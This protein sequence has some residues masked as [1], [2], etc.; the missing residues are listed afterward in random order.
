MFG[1]HLLLTLVCRFGL[2]FCFSQEV[3]PE[4]MDEKDTN[5]APVAARVAA[6]KKDE[7]AIEDNRR[8]MKIDQTIKLMV[9]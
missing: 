6:D 3:Q 1:L 4:L 5:V 7:L 2:T 9:I 8:G